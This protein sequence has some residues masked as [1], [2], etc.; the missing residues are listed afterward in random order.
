MNKFERLEKVLS[1]LFFF[2]LIIITTLFIAIGFKDIELIL[3][4]IQLLL[5]IS[6]SNFKKRHWY[7]YNQLNLK[8]YEKSHEQKRHYQIALAL[9]EIGEREQAVN[10]IETIMKEIA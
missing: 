3:I 1:I 9:M 4:M 7:E 6:Y 2:N 5:Y 10:Y 8:A